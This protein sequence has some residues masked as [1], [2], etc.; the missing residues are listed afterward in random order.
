MA[1]CKQKIENGYYFCKSVWA[2][3][4]FGYKTLLLEYNYM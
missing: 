1:N 2:A 3:I 4:K